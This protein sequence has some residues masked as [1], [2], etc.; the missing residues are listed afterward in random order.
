MVTSHDVA[1]LAGVT[2]PTVSR[3]LRDAPNVS[4]K[5]KA[6]VQEAA[7]KLG[8]VTNATGRALS[9][10]RSDRV[11][12]IVTDLR[13]LF[14]P[15]VIAPIHDELEKL[16]LELVLITDSGAADG[17]ADRARAY[18]L[19]GT[20]LATTTR[21]SPVPYLLKDRGLPFVYFN[22]YS[23]TVPADTVTAA[24][25]SGITELVEHLH[26]LG[27]R[28]IATIHGPQE[29][30]TGYFRALAVRDALG[31][32]GIPLP[33]EYEVEGDF[34]PATGADGV[35][36]LLQLPE[37]PT[38]IICGNDAIALG[39]LNALSEAGVSVPDEMSVTGFDDLPESSWPIISLSTVHFDLQAMATRAAQ[40]VAARV[41]GPADHP[42]HEE[43]ETHFVP[44][45]STGPAP[46]AGRW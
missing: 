17:I 1:R 40:L 8:Y 29:A 36:R 28:R 13:N 31:R 35:R 24:P 27:H 23:T 18:G 15:H 32:L 33:R 39:A 37:R 34:D 4:A 3:A 30:T 10:G 11:G 2:Q 12:L 43:F 38:A 22:R 6:K 45:G 14:Y 7:R 44:R 19:C 46:G 25:T 42:V 5:T 26:G 21:D 41:E 9:R 20:I 16:G